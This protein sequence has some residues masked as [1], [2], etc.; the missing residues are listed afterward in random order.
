MLRD[1]E[2][3]QE[4]VRRH[5]IFMEQIKRAERR[6][7]LSRMFFGGLIWGLGFA[8]GLAAARILH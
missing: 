3:H 7:Y 8:L 1:S 6:R 2:A 4:F 5:A